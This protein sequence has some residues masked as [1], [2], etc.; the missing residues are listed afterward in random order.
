MSA[1]PLKKSLISW[2]EGND[3]LVLSE[4]VLAALSV[5]IPG[6][7]EAWAPTLRTRADSRLAASKIPSTVT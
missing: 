7:A 2:C 3:E 5:Y 6:C 1:H 4:D